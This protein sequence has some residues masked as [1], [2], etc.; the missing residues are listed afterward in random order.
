MVLDLSAT[1]NDDRGGNVSR[2]LVPSHGWP[3]AKPMS[4][5]AF[6]HD[7]G[8]IAQLIATAAHAPQTRTLRRASADD[9]RAIYV[10]AGSREGA[11]VSP[12]GH[13]LTRTI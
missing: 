3:D 13:R 4:C 10:C 6:R 8:F 12:L 1:A 9:A 11:V 7:A 2:A 5:P